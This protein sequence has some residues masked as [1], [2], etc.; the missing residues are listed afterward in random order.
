MATRRVVFGIL[1]ILSFG[2]LLISSYVVWE[3]LK[4]LPA[5]LGFLGV[6]A[7][8]ILCVLFLNAVVA[9]RQD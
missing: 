4:G 2:G 7:S 8:S 3:H 1:V 5:F 6:C 9:R